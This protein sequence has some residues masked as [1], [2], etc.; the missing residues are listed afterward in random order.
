[1]HRENRFYV[2]SCFRKKF[3]MSISTY[4]KDRLSEIEAALQCPVCYAIPRDLPISSC[5]SGHIICQ[6]CRPRVASC[7]TCRQ[8]LPAEST[9]SVVASLIQQVN[10]ECK[11]RDQGCEARMLLGDLELHESKCPERTITV[12]YTHLTLP[13]I[14]LV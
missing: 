2:C 1:M 7:P 10:H 6:R 5:P 11:F 12:S 13:T 3:L 8:S 14:L 9:N 4:T